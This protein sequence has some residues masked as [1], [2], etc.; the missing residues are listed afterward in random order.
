MYSH[1]CFQA[2]FE[3]TFPTKMA[4]EKWKSVKPTQRSQCQSPS[5]F[6]DRYPSSSGSQFH[7]SICVHS[8]IELLDPEVH[9]IMSSIILDSRNRVRSLVAP[10]WSLQW[11]RCGAK[12]GAT[13]ACPPRGPPSQR[14]HLLSP[15]FSYFPLLY[16]G[17]INLWFDKKNLVVLCPPRTGL[18][19]PIEPTF[20]DIAPI[21]WG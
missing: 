2:F 15:K 5:C 7:R 12:R 13:L 17:Q 6:S 3:I 1:V 9:Q 20:V 21:L 19:L 4:T 16:M 18:P 11:D 14:C 10:C 8:Q